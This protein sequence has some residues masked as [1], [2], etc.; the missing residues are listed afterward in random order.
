MTDQV[1]DAYGE[2]VAKVTPRRAVAVADK[3]S[4]LLSR[5][6]VGLI[7]TIALALVAARVFVGV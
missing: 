1:Y 4:R 3:P 7:W 5:F 6:C 2:R